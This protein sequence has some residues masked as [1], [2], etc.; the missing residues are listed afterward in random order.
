[1]K[2][3]PANAQILSNSSPPANRGQQLGGS[4][5]TG[6]NFFTRFLRDEIFAA[7]K[8]QGNFDIVISLSVFIGAI[9]FLRNY[10]DLLAV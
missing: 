9:A 10:P 2:R 7:D 3:T 5:G 4:G 1:M 8:R 6:G